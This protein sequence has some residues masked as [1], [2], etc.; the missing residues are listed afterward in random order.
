MADTTNN[1]ASQGTAPAQQNSQGQQQQQQAPQGTAAPA[2]VAPASTAAPVQQAQAP[3]PTAKD[4]PKDGPF[5]PVASYEKTGNSGLDMALDF[6]GRQGLGLDHPAIQAAINGDF[7]PV[8]A[9]MAEKGVQGYDAYLALAE[10]AFQE[11]D[12][13]KQARANDVRAMGVTIA[14]SEEDL[15][16]VLD[17]AGQ[18]ADEAEKKVAN[19]A[20]ESGGILAEAML[21]YLVNG[22][23]GAT[24]TS[25]TPQK[26]A[27]KETAPAA[28]ATNGQPLSP[29]DYGLAVYELRSKLGSRTESSQEYQN[30][31]RRRA[32]WRG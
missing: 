31:N 28:P 4:A 26:T 14:G 1:A 27:V 11:F 2:T 30:L 8:K 23:R 15:N 7:G 18:N 25:Y 3:T 16:A 32:L 9:I 6:V 22:Y 13:K 24:G 5:G 17:W 20:L 12:Q 10:K 19:L 21:H 29:H